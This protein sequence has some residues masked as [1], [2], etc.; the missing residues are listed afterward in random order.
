[1]IRES[2][3]ITTAIGEDGVP[4]A[5]TVLSPTSNQQRAQCKT[6]PHTVVPIVFLPG[7]M[8]TNLRDTETK[9][10]I[11]GVNSMIGAL[12]QWAFR[13]AATRQRKLNPDRAE[14]DPGQ[15]YSKRSATIPDEKTALSRGLG[16]ISRASYSEFLH[17]LDDTLNLD[18]GTEDDASP[19][20]PWE[21][22]DKGQDWGAEKSFAPITKAESS[23]AW[24]NF[25]CPVY[26]K[27]YNWI[28]SNADSGKVIAGQLQTIIDEWNNRDGFKCEK[29]ILITHSM[30][31]LVARA[32]VHAQM[33]NAADLVLGVIHGVMPATGAPAAYHHCRSG[34]DFPTGIVLG[35]NAAQVTAVIANSPGALELLPTQDYPTGWLQAKAGAGESMMRLPQA[36]PYI[37]IYLQKNAWWRAVDPSLIDPNKVYDDPWGAYSTNLEMASEFHYCLSLSYHSNTYVYYGA[38]SNK[39]VIYNTLVWESSG[40]INM[41]QAELLAAVPVDGSDPVTVRGAGGETARFEIAEPRKGDQSQAGDGTVPAW[42]GASPGIMGGSNIKQ[43][44]RLSGF[45]HQA[46]YDDAIARETVMHSICKLLQQA[47]EL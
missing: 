43:S 28:K 39:F 22:A 8:G 47:R 37:E 38:D 33:G 1:M 29:V 41:N 11:W 10:S 5:K 21:G 17:W 46:S 3:R 4:V 32:A 14:V 27:G 15:S 16:E 44:Y 42:S 45:G 6:L 40:A 35:S 26:A 31:G 24:M 36:E 23:Y 18:L 20:K 34:Y 12:F 7:I 19:W 25:Y 13:S 2:R 9:K 30:G